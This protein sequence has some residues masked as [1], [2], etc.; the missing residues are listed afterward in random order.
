MEHSAENYKTGEHFR[1]THVFTSIALIR[2]EYLLRGKSSHREAA[3]L[4]SSVIDYNG[5]FSLFRTM[6]K[7]SGINYRFNR[8]L[9][10]PIALSQ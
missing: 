2:N 7:L 6:V 3:L 5:Y 1:V 4:L 10:A 8:C 9:S